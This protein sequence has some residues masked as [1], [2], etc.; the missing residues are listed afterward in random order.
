QSRQRFLAPALGPLIYNASI[1]AGGVALAPRLHIAAFAWG[2][3]AGAVVGN[4]V[5]QYAVLRR[6]GLCYRPALAL[7]HPGVRRVGGMMGAV[8]LSLALPQILVEL[9]R[10]FGYGVS[11]GVASAL[12]NTN[13]LMQ[14]PL[15][16][17]GQAL[18]VALL[19]TLSMHASRRDLACFR[20]TLSRSVRFVLFVTLPVS[21]MMMALSTPLVRMVFE[22]G[23]FSAADTALAAPILAAYCAAVPAWSVQAVVARA[24]FAMGDNRTPVWAGFAVLVLFLVLSL[25]LRSALGGPG[26]AL[27]TSFC[28]VVI[29]LLMA[30]VLSRH[31]GGLGGTNIL[32][33]LVKTIAASV[34]AA[35]GAALVGHALAG[36]APTQPWLRGLYQCVAGGALG[37][38]LFLGLAALLRVSE[39]EDVWRG[40][41]ARLRRG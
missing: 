37:A 19:P 28:G 21:A 38:G 7:D 23:Q 30:R 11:A 41:R 9:N 39:V 12:T 6:L 13:R 20:H 16:M 5:L 1:I 15:A 29:S 32:A 31:V 2:A 40:V 17:F 14:A 34:P 22:H 25:V 3:L 36:T 4:V 35:V 27:A 8:T 26:L 18:A 10:A 33:S 24:C